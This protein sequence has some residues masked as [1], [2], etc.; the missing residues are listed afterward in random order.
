MQKSNGLDTKHGLT[1]SNFT[2]EGS[3]EKHVS[4]KNSKFGLHKIVGFH[5]QQHWLL[6]TT[7]LSDELIDL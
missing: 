4:V 6:S 3:V 1:F 5:H 7:M 2:V